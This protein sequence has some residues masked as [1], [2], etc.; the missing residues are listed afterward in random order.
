MGGTI[1]IEADTAMS[2][3]TTDIAATVTGGRQPG[4]NIALTT[5]TLTVHGGRIEAETQGTGRAGDITLAVSNMV[6]QGTTLSSSSADLASGDAGTVTIRGMAGT[7][8]TATTV[9]FTDSTLRTRAEATGA[10]GAITVAA[11]ESLTL[12]NTTLSAT[13]HNG[14]DTPGGTRGDV[15]L[16]AP[17]LTL[18]AAHLEAETTGS[19][20][21]GDIRLEAATVVAQK[22]EITS[23]STATA[24]GNAGTITIQGLDGPDR[25]AETVTLTETRVATE[26]AVAD[27]GDIQIHARDIMRLRDSQITTAVRSG[28][29]GGGNILIDPEFVILQ[30]SQVQADAF[31]GSGGNVRIAAQRVFLADP[32]S[33]VSASSVL[34][35]AGL[36]NIQSPVTNISG[37]LTA[38][39]QTFTSAPE[40][41]HERC[42]ARRWEGRVSTL[43]ARG[44]EGIPARPGGVLPSPLYSI[45]KGTERSGKISETFVQQHTAVPASILR[46]DDNQRLRVGNRPVETFSPIVRNLE[47]SK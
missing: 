33:R 39:P 15:T 2:L 1:T 27:G 47:C 13:V 14:A 41:L 16:Q 46:L 43:I 20:S 30:R 6:A 26:A 12:K 35:I 3:T 28:D 25:L 29:G 24:A 10:G 8:T 23:S 42:A 18:I 5:P 19:R 45:Q 32:D 44:H 4:G 38:L 37:S 9:H 36:V 40:V 21:A 7:G 22:T 31:G 34:G 11:G 17:L